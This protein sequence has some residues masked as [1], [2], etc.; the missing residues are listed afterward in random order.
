[1][2]EDDRLLAADMQ[3]GCDGK[4]FAFAADENGFDFRFLF[5][6]SKEGPADVVGQPDDVS[7][8]MLEE[9]VPYFGSGEH[10]LSI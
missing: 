3:T 10:G 9:A 8:S 6:N 2:D 5:E 4:G 1:M 7:N